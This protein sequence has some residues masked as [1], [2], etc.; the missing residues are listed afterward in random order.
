MQIEAKAKYDIPALLALTRATMYGGHVIIAGGLFLFATAVTLTGAGL[1]LFAGQEVFLTAVA[2]AA[3]LAG[4]GTFLYTYFLAPKKQ[5]RKLS[6]NGE[7]TVSYLF[8]QEGVQIFVKSD[9][10]EENAN[11]KYTVLYKIV[12]IKN[13]IFLYINSRSAYI[14]DKQTVKEEDLPLLHNAFCACGVRYVCR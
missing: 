10:M 11:I 4:D 6:K 13:Y 9:A 5:Y 14:V 1:L 12:E 2:L 7:I 8:G 3:V